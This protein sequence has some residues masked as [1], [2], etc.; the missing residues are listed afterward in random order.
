MQQAEKNMDLERKRK[1][2]RMTKFSAL[3]LNEWN[4]FNQNWEQVLRKN[5]RVW[6]GHTRIRSSSGRS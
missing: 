4:T 3:V 2:L 1:E 6:F 5:K